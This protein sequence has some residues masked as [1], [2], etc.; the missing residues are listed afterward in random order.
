MVVGAAAEARPATPE[1]LTVVLTQVQGN[2]TIAEATVPSGTR[3]VPPEPR[4]AQ[5]L[6]IVR[7]G[8]TVHLPVG[9]GVGFVCSTD[10]WVE[11]NESK[12][13]RVTEDLCRSGKPLPPGTYRKLAPGAGRLRSLKN[14]LVLEGDTR[15]V[16]DEDFGV[17]I[18]LSPRNTAILEGRPTLVWIPVSEAT[19]YEIELTGP[20]PFRL[21]LDASEV[22]CAATWGDVTVCT[23]PYP[24]K[25]PDLPR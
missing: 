9:A 23:L 11:V 22:G 1:E 6:Q 18:L 5:F 17:P 2:V 16:G 24:A 19:D 10:R 8:D 12:Y 13:Q 4:R 3:A 20:T 7:Y 21:R 15:G 14:A 25:E